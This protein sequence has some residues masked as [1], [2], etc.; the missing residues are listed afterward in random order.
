MKLYRLLVML[1]LVLAGIIDGFQR[2]AYAQSSTESVVWLLHGSGDGVEQ[3]PDIGGGFFVARIHGNLQGKY[4]SVTTYD[5][6][7]DQIDLLVNTGDAYYGIVPFNFDAYKLYHVSGGLIE[8]KAT[9]EWSIE[10]ISLSS[11]KPA[12]SSQS[13]IGYGDSVFY[14]RGNALKAGVAGN[15]KFK[16]FS[17]SAIGIDSG[18]VDSD[19]LVNTSDPYQGDVRLPRNKDGFILIVKSSDTWV[20]LF[21]SSKK[22]NDFDTRAASLKTNP[23][24]PF[25]DIFARPTVV[26]QPTAT[27][28]KTASPT[29]S[30]QKT[31]SATVTPQQATTITATVTP[32][33]TAKSD[34]VTGI[35]NRDANL[36]AGPGTNHKI[37]GGVK[38]GQKITVASFDPD[39]SWLQMDNGAWIAAFLVDLDQ[40]NQSVQKTAEPSP[41][42]TPSG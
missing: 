24:S 37:V 28:Q 1:S 23:Y 36:R 18:N 39:G 14:V 9:G 15:K 38:A 30:P 20:I 5:S 7:G 25:K 6:L 34:V 16:Y 10:V 3:I 13:I 19:L 4:F 17:L 26:T 27:A 42:P 11:L 8:V 40:Q 31:I 33:G 22:D 2:P 29:P 35:V 41:T 21:N 12:Y 32:T